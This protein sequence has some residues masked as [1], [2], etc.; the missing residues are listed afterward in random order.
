MLYIY[1]CFHLSTEILV[2]LVES[3]WL[4]KQ[5]V[6]SSIPNKA[7]NFVVHD[8]F[9]AVVELTYSN[10]TAVYVLV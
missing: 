3:L 4:R 5:K 8:T 10:S 1:I 6:E 9:I 7:E 2:G